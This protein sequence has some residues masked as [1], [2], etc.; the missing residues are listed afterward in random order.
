MYTVFDDVQML[1]LA[2]PRRWKRNKPA[3]QVVQFA[4]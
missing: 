4:D 2:L 1:V 3:R